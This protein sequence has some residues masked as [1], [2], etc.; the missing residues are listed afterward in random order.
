MNM[1][2]PSRRSEP[3]AG[4]VG[5]DFRRGAGRRGRGGAPPGPGS[6]PAQ[7]SIRM[8]WIGFAFLVVLPLRH[9]ARCHVRAGCL[10]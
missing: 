3:A 8:R 6:R 5:A 4:A 2:S 10:Q 1:R 7:L 9:C